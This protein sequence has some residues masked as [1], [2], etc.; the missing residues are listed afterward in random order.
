MTNRIYKTGDPIYRMPL[1]KIGTLVFLPLILAACGVMQID[2]RV[3]PN[4]TSTSPEAAVSAT[5]AFPP[6]WTPTPTG[7]LAP[8]L[9]LA[10]LTAYEPGHPLAFAMVQMNDTARGWAVT[11]DG[12]IVKT[13]DGGTVW[14]EVTPPAGSVTARGFSSWDMQTA[15]AAPAMAANPSAP[16]STGVVWRTS[17]GGDHWQQIVLP[18]KMDQET[19]DQA[20]AR[21][22]EPQAF[23][24][25]DAKTGWLLA[26]VNG[27]KET[28]TVEIFHTTDGGAVW[29]RVTDTIAGS[30]PHCAENISFSDPQTGLLISS[31]PPYRVKND[32][33]Y[34]TEYKSTTGGKAWQAGERD[35]LIGYWITHG[36][37]N[38]GC[39]FHT[40]K[41]GTAQLG[42]TCVDSNTREENEVLVDISKN[43]GLAD[44]G[45][46]AFYLVRD[47]RGRNGWTFN[48]PGQ[49]GFG[50][51]YIDKEW[52][53]TPTSVDWDH[54]EFYCLGASLTCWVT[55]HKGV[56][57]AFL[58]TSDGGKKWAELK[59]ATAD[60]QS[61]CVTGKLSQL[62]HA[63][64]G[65]T[66]TEKFA[67]EFSPDWKTFATT[68][69][70][71]ARLWSVDTKTAGA[72][73]E[74]HTGKVISV[75]F[76]PS[77]GL[78]ATGG[79]DGQIRLWDV[80]Q[81]KILRTISNQN[82]AVES[83][84]FSPDG[85]LLAS[86]AWDY[87]VRLW[88][89]TDGQL[90]SSQT[91]HHGWI[92]GLAF[93]PSGSRLASASADHSVMLWD[94]DS[95][96]LAIRHSLAAH[97]DSVENVVF[98][99]DGS[100]VASASAD[101][102][103]ALW[104]A[105][106]GALQRTIIGFSQP[107]TGVAFSPD[108]KLL[109]TGTR[110]G[111]VQLWRAGDG[112]RLC[113]ISDLSNSTAAITVPANAFSRDGSRA[114]WGSS[115]GTVWVWEQMVSDN[116]ITKTVPSRATLLKVIANK[117]WQNMGVY[118]TG[119]SHVIIEYKSGLWF[120]GAGDGGGHDASGNPNPWICSWSGC[121][122]PLHDFPKYA[123]IGRI[124][125][126]GH[127]LKVGNRLGLTAEA[128]G[129]LYLRPNYGDGDIAFFH[130]EGAIQVSITT[131]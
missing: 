114:A 6:A 31:C 60:P 40:A 18:L 118:I 79:A 117:G 53:G 63:P 23:S 26:R 8:P 41:P 94:V 130:P 105:D 61:I 103:V 71:S 86:G 122:E 92:K 95:A 81:G 15:W 124:G 37:P 102:T 112:A 12:H 34:I 106:T 89:V 48:P 76:S 59:P 67:L 13:A 69:E 77:G 123:L 27:E 20:G 64:T 72:L 56:A 16:I 38:G 121:H 4:P 101:G 75:A 11:A 55:A 108:G 44:I 93:S 32:N 52:Y 33:I 100:R 50:A 30:L 78:M 128:S 119:G 36:T 88:R 58:R 97:T 73:L 25:V 51:I 65:N 113:S 98:S 109:L 120:T 111:Q 127:M 57:T 107:V 74:G 96:S 70:N 54:V 24:F 14:K 29:E 83:L 42:A 87:A 85:Q 21:K 66:L 5:T 17:D 91:M 3:A 1:L 28:D 49:N 125:E 35:M 43:Y 39:V 90:L 47:G 19:A 22:F 62:A 68:K 99:P 7:T 10:G 104:N 131:Q 9:E 129:T 116:D 46:S 126:S 110:G 115:D 80:A 45:G 84:A 82:S 2:I